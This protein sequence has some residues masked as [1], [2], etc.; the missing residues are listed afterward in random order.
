M[1]NASRKNAV[2]IGSSITGLSA[3]RILSEHFERVT[4]I[5]RDH[6]TGSSDFRSGA[7]QARHA[8]TL[9]PR[10]QSILERRFPGIFDEMVALGAISLDRSDDIQFFEDGS[11]KSPGRKGTHR[12]LY[13]SRP[14]L[15]SA[16]YRRVAAIKNVYVL[17]DFEATGLVLDESGEN[18]AGVSLRGRG[19][20]SNE[21]MTLEAELVLDATGRNSQAPR[22]LTS[23]GYP[24]PEEW[25]V[26]AKVGYSSR[27][28]QAPK[29]FNPGWKAIYIRPEPPY[30]TRGG[31]LIPM[32]DGRW[33]VTLLGVCGDYPPGDERGFFE[34]AR[35]LPTLELYNAIRKAKPLGEGSGFR[36][37]A[38]RVRRYDKL[39][40][41]PGGFMVAGDAA[42]ALNPIGAQ[43]MTAA[44]IGVEGLDRVLR[45]EQNPQ[46]RIALSK[47]F[48]SELA[49][50]VGRIWKITVQSEWD[51]PETSLKD[52]TESLYPRGLNAAPAGA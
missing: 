19:E 15:E 22:W 43:G 3:A 27:A 25:Q 17:T 35:S 18:V 12:N 14:L 39:S 9:Q 2:V 49:K 44:L 28:F 34:F 46:D 45:S 50:Q 32:E 42:F 21:Q 7:P 33:C 13:A 38:N 4:L 48:Q 1:T 10:G 30:G 6:E 24:A 41:I 51:W 40:R 29:G 5:D 36:R 26:D 16:I 37:T 31:M 20:R 47:D 11:W 52:N 8:H 23:L